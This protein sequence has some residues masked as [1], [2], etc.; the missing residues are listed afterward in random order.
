MKYIK[1][2][3]ILKFDVENIRDELVLENI[4]YYLNEAEKGKEL[5]FTNK[6]EAKILLRDLFL[7]INKEYTYYNK[8]KSNIFSDY[9]SSVP[10]NYIEEISNIKLRKREINNLNNLLTNYSLFNYLMY[11]R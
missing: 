3:G 4:N 9:K 11:A 6:K 1:Y 7:K 2:N 8:I 10:I 5:I